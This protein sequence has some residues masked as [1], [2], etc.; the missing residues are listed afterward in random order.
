MHFDHAT[1]GQRVSDLVRMGQNKNI[2]EDRPWVGGDWVKAFSERIC[3]VTGT[4][5][6]KF[7]ACTSLFLDGGDLMRIR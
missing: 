1:A 6:S 2:C 3:A 7:P 5:N 4:G